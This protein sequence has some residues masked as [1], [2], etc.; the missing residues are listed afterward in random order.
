M[1]LV[2]YPL[3][4]SMVDAHWQYTFLVDVDAIVADDLV[5]RVIFDCDEYVERLHK[6]LTIYIKYQ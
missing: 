1:L 6:Y 5:T 2:R 4:S 3:K